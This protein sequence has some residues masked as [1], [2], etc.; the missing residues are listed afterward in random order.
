MQKH[1]SMYTGCIQ[2]EAGGQG[3]R[4][5]S[6]VNEIQSGSTESW[7]RSAFTCSWL[8]IWGLPKIPGELFWSVDAY[9]L[10]G[11]SKVHT[12]SVHP[13]H[14]FYLAK[15]TSLPD[16][17]TSVM[18]RRTALMWACSLKLMKELTAGATVGAE[19]RCIRTCTKTNTSTVTTM[20]CKYSRNIDPISLRCWKHRLD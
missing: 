5:V 19:A 16:R 11:Q 13:P 2:T 1:T 14:C 20:C 12:Q 18:W 4:G 3:D 8:D 17:S 10:W 9:E 15:R 6:N 7:H